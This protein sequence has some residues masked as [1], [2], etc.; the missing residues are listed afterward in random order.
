MK[1]RSGN[2]SEIYLEKAFSKIK[3]KP[4]QLAP[5]VKILVE[6]SLMFLVN[7]SI[8]EVNIEKKIHIKPFNEL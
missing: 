5:K 3:F 1:W 4:Q 7:E 8:S 2:F 6:A